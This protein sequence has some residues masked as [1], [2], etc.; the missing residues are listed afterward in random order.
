MQDQAQQILNIVNAAGHS[1]DIDFAG[2]LDIFGFGAD[3]NSEQSLQGVFEAF[4]ISGK[5]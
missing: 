2:F 5:G 4:D 1:G 3:S